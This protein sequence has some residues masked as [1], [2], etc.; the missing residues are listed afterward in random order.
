MAKAKSLY[1]TAISL[2]NQKTRSVLSPEER[3]AVIDA[4]KAAQSKLPR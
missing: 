2:A 3:Q 1:A 4:A